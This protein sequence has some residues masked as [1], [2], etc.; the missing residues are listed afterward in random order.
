[1]APPVQEPSADENV[2]S[3]VVHVAFAGS[4]HVHGVQSRE[5]VAPP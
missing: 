1:M 2:S 4:P 3:V 5:S